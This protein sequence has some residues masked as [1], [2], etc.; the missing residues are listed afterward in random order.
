MERKL[1]NEEM[2]RIIDAISPIYKEGQRHT[3]IVYLTGW[4]YKAR[5]SHESAKRLIKLICDVFADEECHDRLYTLDRT[6]GLKGN[7]PPEYK[8]KTKNGIFELLVNAFRNKEEAK[9]KLKVLEEILETK[10]RK[11]ILFYLS[12]PDEEK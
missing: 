2:L 4:L 8:F 7:Q 3:V 10:G 12:K 1:S 11:T 9:I 6:Y 5:I